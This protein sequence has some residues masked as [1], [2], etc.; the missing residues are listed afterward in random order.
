MD[1]ALQKAPAPCRDADAWRT[2]G[3]VR[4]PYL[5]TD[6]AVVEIFDLLPDRAKLKQAFDLTP[7]QPV[8]IGSIGWDTAQEKEYRN[9]L[10]RLGQ[11]AKFFAKGSSQARDQINALGAAATTILTVTIPKLYSEDARLLGFPLS[12]SLPDKKPYNQPSAAIGRDNLR[13]DIIDAYVS[14][15]QLLWCA[16]F[17]MAQ[18]EAYLE[19]R[20]AYE[21]P[22]KPTPGG[23]LD[24]AWTQYEPVEFDEIEEWGIDKPLQT[25]PEPETESPL[26]EEPETES[27]GGAAIAVV[28][29]LG[30]GAFLLLRR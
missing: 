5:G 28:A 30:I 4:Y 29:A 24:P 26:V 16:Q 8:P 22:I 7:T 19:N 18:A 6:V 23:L 25:G 10:S 21:A 12:Q 2:S 9:E 15:A 3:D 11:K 27:G 17:G 1:P 13:H 14:A 20:D